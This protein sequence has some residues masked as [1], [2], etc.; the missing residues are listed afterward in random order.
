M[1]GESCLYDRVALRFKG[2]NIAYNLIIMKLDLRDDLA[3]RLIN[4]KVLNNRLV[5]GILL[6]NLEFVMISRTLR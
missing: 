5:V 2:G 6:I 3:A 1:S 4:N